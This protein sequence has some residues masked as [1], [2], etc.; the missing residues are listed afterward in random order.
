MKKW[1]CIYCR[2]SNQFVS[3][4]QAVLHQKDCLAVWKKER[5][6]EKKK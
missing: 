2:K 5:Q 1:F 3:L 4:D 6:D